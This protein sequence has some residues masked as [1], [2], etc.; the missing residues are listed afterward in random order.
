[1]GKQRWPLWVW[2]LHL[3]PALSL[4]AVAGLR[5]SLEETFPADW[6][7]TLLAFAL[8][9]VWLSAALGMLIAPK[10]RDWIVTRRKE[11][12]LSAATLGICAILA[13]LALTLVG[14]VPTIEEQRSRSVAY[15]VGHFTNQRLIPQEVL[16][17]G[18]GILRVNE[19][20]FRGGEIAAQPAPDRPRIIVLGGSQAFD[21]SGG[22]WPALIEEELGKLGQSVEVIN[23]GVPGHS[24]FDSLGKLLTDLWTL[25]PDVLFLCQAW[26]DIK[27]FKWIA[28][29]NPYRG[30]PPK[31]VGTWRKD[32]RLFPSGI[33]WLLSHSAVYRQFRWGFAQLLYYEE[34]DLQTFDENL[35]PQPIAMDSWGVEQYRLNLSLIARIA[36]EIGAEL[37]LCKQ[38]RLIIAGGNGNDQDLAQT[39]G[40]RNLGLSRSDMLRAFEL[41]EQIVED[42]A[43]EEGLRVADLS[44]A[45]SGRREYFDD[46]IHFTPAGGRAAAALAAQALLEPVVEAIKAKQAR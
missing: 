11:W 21:Y 38:A 43:R 14:I 36:K 42:I 12:C 24:T 18:G 22:N 23:A 17:N 31:E 41:T 28:P 32:W 34:G 45:M 29:S 10:G 9:L 7:M 19:R 33:D 46:H 3:V 39:Y 27:Y 13:D 26:N 6:R 8:G 4:I 37:V 5:Q 16:L 25:K 1:M 2:S 44:Q 40:Q 20:G 35:K 30:L 15:T